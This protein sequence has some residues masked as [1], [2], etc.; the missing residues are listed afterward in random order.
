MSY[1]KVL[2]Y[3]W[4]SRGDVQP[5]LA[6]ALRLKELGKDVTMFVTPPSDDLCRKAGIKCVTASESGDFFAALDGLD[7]SDMSFF[8][9]IRQAR[10][11]KA[12]QERPEHQAALTADLKA[13][14]ELAQEFQPDVIIHSGFAYALYASVGEAL[15]VPVIRYDLQPNYP[16]S[17]IGFFKQVREGCL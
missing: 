10:A 13:G 4:G 3:S 2:I 12:Y 11:I 7:P 16:T 5:P 8:N 17:E 15:G 14:Y 6:L 9:V 1:T